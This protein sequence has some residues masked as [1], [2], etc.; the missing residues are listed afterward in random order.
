M[1]VAEMMQP[2]SFVPNIHYRDLEGVFDVIQS[3]IIDPKKASGYPYCVQSQPTNAQ[4]LG[5]YGEKGFAQHVLNEWDNLDFE[6]KDF[7]KGEPTKRTKLEK[8]MPRCI[9]GFPL[10]VTVKHASVFNELAVVL[11]KQWKKTPVN[12]AFSPANPGHIEHLAEWLP[13]KVW[14][15]DKSNWDYMMHS[16]IAAAACGV[17]KKLAIQPKEWTAE[18]YQQYLSDID[19]CFKQVFECATYRTSDGHAYKPHESGI[20]KSGWYMTIAINSISQLA[21]HVMTCMRL[22]MSDEEILDLP[23][24]AGGD[25]V[26]QSPVPA[27][28]EKYVQAA[29]E[30]GVEMEIHER[31]DL[32]HSEYFSN[33]LRM[34]KEGPTYHP[35]R[36]TKHIEHLRVVKLEHLG[37]ALCSHME[38]YRHDDAKFAVLRKMYLTLNEKHP[39]ELPIHKLS[40]QSLLLARQYG[41]EHALTGS[42]S[43]SW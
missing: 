32:Y 11:V 17:V 25:D 9:A 41:Y 42:T 27:G 37:D 23:I 33:D 39:H 31:E 24:F 16:W 7:L 36:W 43:C 18:Q 22:S 5:A 35:K 1:L 4:V 26:N 6:I 19:N 2:A 14:E 10:H 21:V 30:L 12:Y 20:M 29:Q 40:S 38:N 15:S 13:G 3:S 8:G 34:G 28:I